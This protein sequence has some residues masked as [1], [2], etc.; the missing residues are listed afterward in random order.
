MVEGGKLDFFSQ[1]LCAV[2]LIYL[3][4]M[5]PRHFSINVLFVRFAMRHLLNF[6]FSGTSDV[7]V[8]FLLF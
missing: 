4:D 7:R 5:L 8:Y 2:L 1:A 6:F 3:A